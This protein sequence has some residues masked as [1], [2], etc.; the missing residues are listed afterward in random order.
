[1]PLLDN[2]ARRHRC[3]STT[4]APRCSPCCSA[5][6]RSRAAWRRSA[7]GA[8]PGPVAHRLR[9]AQGWPGGALPTLPRPLAALGALLAKRC[10]WRRRIARP[11]AW[12]ARQNLAAA[13]PLA[14]ACEDCCPPPAA[15]LHRLA[16]RGG[17]RRAADAP[18]ALLALLALVWPGTALS[19][20][21]LRPG[22]TPRRCIAGWPARLAG[23]GGALLDAALASACCCAAGRRRALQTQIALMLA[24]SALIAWL[25]PHYSFDPFQGVGKNPVRLAPA[26]G[27]CGLQPCAA[28]SRR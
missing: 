3:T 10:G 12:R 17:Q 26:C 8:D 25:L 27:C 2:R 22:P 14:Q 13:E 5:G 23:A 4:C 18:G 7:P 20:P 15:R 19:R 1:M 16:A 11:C 21:R 28:R 24:C 6:R 9:A